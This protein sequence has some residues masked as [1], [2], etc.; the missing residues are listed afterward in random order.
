MS[1]SDLIH[2]TLLTGEQ[3]VAVGSQA[4]LRFLPVSPMPPLFEKIALHIRLSCW[5]W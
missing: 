4:T 5:S 1:Q 2:T 3:G